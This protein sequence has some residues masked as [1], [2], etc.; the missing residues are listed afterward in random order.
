MH[1]KPTKPRV[2]NVK[3]KSGGGSIKVHLIAES[4]ENPSDM[5]LAKV[6]SEQ[7]K[8]QKPGQASMSREKQG[9][10]SPSEPDR[11]V[12]KQS[13]Q[14]NGGGGKLAPE[15]A[16]KPRSPLLMPKKSGGNGGG[17]GGGERSTLHSRYEMS[18][19]H[20][21][22]SVSAVCQSCVSGVWGCGKRL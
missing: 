16:P 20:C 19:G 21:L 17:G 8:Q 18:S 2:L 6:D 7:T 15:V 14:R 10:H 1:Y 12:G 11:Q 3:K 5:A 9:K 22:E 13:L 4:P